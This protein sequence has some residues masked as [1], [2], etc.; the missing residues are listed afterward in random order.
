M[1]G[2]DGFGYANDRGRWVKIPQVGQVIIG[3]M[4]K[5][6]LVPVLTVAP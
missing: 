2:S 5:S 6:V 3:Y 1:I 4:S